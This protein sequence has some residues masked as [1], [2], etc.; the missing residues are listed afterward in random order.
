[1]YFYFHSNVFLLSLENLG[2]RKKD[3]DKVCKY[4]LN[5]RE[6]HKRQT[7]AEEYEQ[8]LRFY[9]QTLGK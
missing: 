7:S 3:I 5:Q 2:Q 9:Q 1:M 8:F 4:I 6:H